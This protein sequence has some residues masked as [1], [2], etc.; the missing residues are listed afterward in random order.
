MRAIFAVIL[1]KV[2]RLRTEETGIS[3]QL[4]TALLRL[5]NYLT[6]FIGPIWNW[7]IPAPEYRIEREG[8]LAWGYDTV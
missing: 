1:P 3:V 2:L 6:I 8:L 4:N 5:S 7:P